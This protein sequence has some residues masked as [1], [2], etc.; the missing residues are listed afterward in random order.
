MYGMSFLNRIEG[1]FTAY[2]YIQYSYYCGI[3]RRSV[4]MVHGQ[5][6]V[7]EWF[8][9]INYKDFASSYNIRN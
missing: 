9:L 1:A 6:R 4:I 5:R 8:I 7:F 3:R 2:M